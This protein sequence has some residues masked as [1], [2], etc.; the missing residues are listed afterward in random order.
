MIHFNAS[1]IL[2]PVDFSDTS[3]LAIK[4]GAY[5]AQLLKSELH[6]LHV[7]NAPFISQN[8]FLP[9]VD[10]EDNS[11]IEKKALEK[12]AQLSGDVKKEYTINAQCIIKVGNPSIEISNVA[13]EIGAI[14]GVSKK[15]AE[16][17]KYRVMEKLDAGFGICNALQGVPGSIC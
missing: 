2:I 10:I 9:V 4:H 6:L 12:L 11:A 16:F 14:L 17:H 3:L 13:K 5:M 7:I 1:K 15:T 8:M